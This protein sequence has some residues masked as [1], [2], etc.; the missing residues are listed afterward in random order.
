MRGLKTTAGFIGGRREL[1]KIVLSSFGLFC[2]L[3]GL[4]EICRVI[5][6]YADS[7]GF[8]VGFPFEIGLYA[9]GMVW[10]VKQY[11]RTFSEA[12]R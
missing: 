9:V 6:L 3:L 8:W 10:A 5:L 1:K 11:G 2:V 7:Y 12:R 4:V